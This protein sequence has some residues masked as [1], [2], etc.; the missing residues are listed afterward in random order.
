MYEFLDKINGP[1]D[2]K[3][4]S[5]D[6]LEKLCA[7]V[8]GYMVECCS[9]NPGHLAS[10]LGAVELIVGYH[11]VFDSPADKIVFDVGHQAYA[12]KIL[13]GR[14]EAFASMRT[15]DGISGFPRRE[16]SEFDAFGVGHSSTSVS[17]ALGLAEAARIKGSAEKVTALIGDGALTGGMAFE[18]LNN[19]GASNADLLVILNDNNQSIDNNRGALH[20]YLLR[21]TTSNRYNIVKERVW[22]LLGDRSLRRFIQR[23]VRSFKSWLVKKTG[24][25]LFESL[26]FRY[27]GPIDGNDISQVVEI[28]VKLRSMQGPRIVHCITTKGRGY[29]PAEADP[30]TWHAPG[31][32]NHLTGERIISPHPYARYQD[33]FG[34]VLL[35]LAGMD[36]KVVGIT[37]AMSQG[38]GMNLLAE[39][40]P[41]QFFDV[42]IEEEHAVTFSAGLAAGGL[43]PFCNL[44]SAFSQRA[45]DQI[46]HDVA[47]QKL[48]VVL[49]FDRAGLAGEDGA[50]HQGMFDLAAYRSIPNTIVSAPKDELE[51]RQLMFTA[52]RHTTGPFIIRYPR[53]MGEGADWENAPFKEY[54]IGRAEA[55]LEG[56]DVAVITIGPSAYAALEAA[57]AFPG[58]VGVFNFRFLKPLDTETL[59]GIAARYRAIITVEDGAL[60]GGL[61]GAVCEHLASCGYNIRIEGIGVRDEFVQQARQ[62]EQR[63]EY[64]ICAAGIEKSLR[65]V[66]GE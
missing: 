23:W 35:E 39:A 17:A 13:T 36:D 46:I 6:E 63:E 8:R 38:C 49:C 32:F 45:Y 4:L 64:G 28:L 65:K 37:P 47:L 61:Y 11:Y 31:K 59:N 66:F 50:T 43:K 56:S 53:G 41:Q 12:H 21:I 26:G 33:V 3:K 60:A 10:S 29:A 7:E 27:F 22:R 62:S 54:E 19:A 15:K 42:G 16:E 51:L 30:V 57:K 52:Y 40:R 58:K 2:L 25:D 34:K 18:G 24:G 44:Y 5:V 9:R 1:A 48:P 14:R 20:N 55:L